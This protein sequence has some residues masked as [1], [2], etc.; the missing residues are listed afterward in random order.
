MRFLN[1]LLFPFSILYDLGT[2]ARN[3]LFDIGYKKSFDFDTRVVAVGNLSVGGTGKSPM[4]EYIIRKLHEKYKITTL[5]RGYGRK[6]KGFRI[7]TDT[8]NAKSIGDE[9]MQFYRKFGDI[10]VAVGEERA[11]AIPF[12]LA[13]RPETEVIVLDDAYQHRTVLPDFNIL[14]TDYQKPFFND[15]VLPAGRLRE[16]RKGAARADAIVVTKCP[17]SMDENQRDMFKNEISKYS[18]AP[19]FFSGIRY[20][21]PVHVFGEA[22][23]SGNIFLFSGIANPSKLSSYV[24]TQFNLLGEK[25]FTDH[26]QY[27]NEDIRELNLKLQAI[28]APDKGFLTTEKDMVKFLDGDFEN[29]F[30]EF[31]LF[32]LPIETYFLEDGNKFDEMLLKTLKSV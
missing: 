7:A 30:S 25:H 12:I 29:K 18:T 6:T 9:P 24:K 1:S 4:V 21:D 22:P 27:K 3:Y 11:V 10:N 2:R 20:L 13:E 15:Y 26:H 28:D 32:Y 8:D 23:F 14:L 16:A 17:E 5:S 31:P 19:V